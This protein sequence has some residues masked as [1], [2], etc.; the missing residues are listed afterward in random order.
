MLVADTVDDPVGTLG[1]NYQP[2]N[3]RLLRFSHVHNPR[4]VWTRKCLLVLLTTV[5]ISVTI[6]KSSSD[7]PVA[8]D[9]D[10]VTNDCQLTFTPVIQP[11]Y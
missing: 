10:F 8:L 3:V 7:P 9:L 2:E 11:S 1:P 5:I 6:L 4:G